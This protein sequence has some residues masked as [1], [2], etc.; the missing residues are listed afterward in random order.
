MTGN[1][2]TD[3]RFRC[4]DLTPTDRPAWNSDGRPEV[5]EIAGDGVLRRRFG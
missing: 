2:L 5:D 3:M 4:Q 1:N